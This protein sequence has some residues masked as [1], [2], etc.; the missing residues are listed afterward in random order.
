MDLTDLPRLAVVGDVCPCRTQGGELQLYRLLAD[1]PTDRLFVVHGARSP[2]FVADKLLPG[3]PHEVVIPEYALP[4]VLRTRWLPFWRAIELSLTGRYAGRV[5]ELLATFRPEA[6]L[7]VTDNTLWVAAAGAAMRL[8]LPL[9]LVQHDDVASKS[10]G[11][12]P[13]RLHR[14][15]RWLFNRVL[16]R[17]YRQAAARF[18]V[19][20][21]MAE[22]YARRFGPTADVLYPSR[23]DDSPEPK[24][25]VNPELI[26]R[27]PVVAF[28][29]ALYTEGAR[30]LLR[31]L[32]DILAKLGGRLDLYGRHDPAAL[33]VFRLDRSNVCAAGFLPHRVM[34][35]RM[36]ETAHALFLPA[37][38]LPA[39]ATD[40][41]TLFPSKLADYTAVGLP[42]LA[43]G[44]AYSSAM[45]WVAD[46]PDA[47]V[48]IVD[49]ADGQ[50]QAVLGQLASDADFARGL[51]E[52]AVRAGTRDF[53][54]DAA[55]DKLHRTLLRVAPSAMNHGVLLGGRR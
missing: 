14:L 22:T 26:G 33:R 9:V 34:A 11:N 32:A 13:K 43:W 29:G 27:L 38:F 44:P 10:T 8:K 54:R 25:R 28:V 15:T 40:V 47:A 24:V 2:Y 6:I 53:G 5:T 37:S 3:V 52:Q 46:N 18:C 49:E 36:G 35:E 17:V 4:R 51:G 39:E 19:S 1:Y 7:T 31:R 16:G 20:P 55:A 48:A 41:S 42:V 21:G 12:S 23:G 45:R 50:V 30:E